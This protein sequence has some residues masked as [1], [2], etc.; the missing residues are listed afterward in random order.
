VLIELQEGLPKPDY[1]FM[2]RCYV[3]LGDAGAVAVILN[4]LLR[5]DQVG[6]PVRRA[7]PM[8]LLRLNVAAYTYQMA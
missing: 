1:G 8:R 4:R 7:W 2:C 3:F 5:G 6:C